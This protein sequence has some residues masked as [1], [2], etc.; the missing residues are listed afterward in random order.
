MSMV[1]RTKLGADADPELFGNTQVSLTSRSSR[2]EDM[3]RT[4]R[5]IGFAVVATAVALILSAFN[6]SEK[7]LPRRCVR[8]SMSELA[9]LMLSN[10]MRRSERCSGPID[11]LIS[12]KRE[13]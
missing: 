11:F 7:L 2:W 3:G 8:S 1:T 5:E 10:R 6:P 4:S 13:S 12:S 9:R